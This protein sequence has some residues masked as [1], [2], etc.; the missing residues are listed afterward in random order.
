MWNFKATLHNVV[1][2]LCSEFE[3]MAVWQ[4]KAGSCL[5]ENR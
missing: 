2:R 5:L 4:M 3:Y 1:L